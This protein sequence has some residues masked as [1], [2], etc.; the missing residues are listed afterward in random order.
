MI[1]IKI[2][3]IQKKIVFIAKLFKFAYYYIDIL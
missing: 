2:D 1:F 3:L